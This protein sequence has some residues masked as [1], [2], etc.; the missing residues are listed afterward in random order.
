MSLKANKSRLTGLTKDIL[1]RW[2]G[3][4]KYWRDAKGAEFDHRFMR[5]LFPQVNQA[6]AALEKLDELLNKIR[7]ECE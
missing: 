1:L 3:T 6:A 4:Q 7:S 2:E 5:E